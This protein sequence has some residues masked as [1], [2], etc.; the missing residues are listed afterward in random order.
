MGQPRHGVCLC[1]FRRSGSPALGDRVTNWT[2]LNEPWVH[3]Y[4]GHATGVHAPGLLDRQ[5]A[6]DA[7]H[8][9]MLGHGLAVPR[10]RAHLPP[11]GNVGITLSL[12]PIY[13]IDD[14][15]ETVRDV[16]LADEFNNSWFLDPLYRGAYPEQFFEHMGL[17]PPPIQPDDLKTISVPL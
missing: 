14:R 17:G 10:I 7:A 16:Q 9:L 12:V 5:A 1:R 6:I 15:D 2:T 11:T 8:H 4:L 3:A 13:G